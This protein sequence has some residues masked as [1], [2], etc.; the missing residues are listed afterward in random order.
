MHNLRYTDAMPIQEQ[1]PNPMAAQM[2]ELVSNQALT[3][4]VTKLSNTFL[5]DHFFLQPTQTSRVGERAEPLPDCDFIQSNLPAPRPTTATKEGRAKM[6]KRQE[7]TLHQ[8]RRRSSHQQEGRRIQLR[9][10]RIRQ[11]VQTILL[12]SQDASF[13]LRLYEAF[14]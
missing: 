6:T 13:C 2:S 12:Y 3:Q 7:R 14:V 4:L 5:D 10:G 11:L 9:E 1:I 8:K